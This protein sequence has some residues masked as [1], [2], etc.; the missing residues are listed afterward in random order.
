MGAPRQGSSILAT[1]CPEFRTPTTRRTS[2]SFCIFAAS[3]PVCTPPV[4]ASDITVITKDGAPA[5]L[6]RAGH[7]VRVAST[8]RSI[9]CARRFS[10][11]TPQ[12]SP[13]P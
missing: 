8:R 7:Q 9:T 4:A 12:P 6:V 11:T 5:V 10:T 3:S 2:S 13:R 1:E